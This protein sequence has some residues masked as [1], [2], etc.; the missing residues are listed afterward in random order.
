M[1]SRSSKA[2]HQ[3]QPLSR[4]RKANPKRSSSRAGARAGQERCER[5]R[6]S[7]HPRRHPRVPRP[8]P[9]RR[10]RRA[11][12][13][14]QASLSEA[15]R[16]T[17]RAERQ[18]GGTHQRSTAVFAFRFFYEVSRS[19]FQSPIWTIDQSSGKPHDT[20]TR[21]FE[22][23]I[24]LLRRSLDHSQNSIRNSYNRYCTLGAGTDQGHARGLRNRLGLTT[25]R[26]RA[27]EREP[28]LQAAVADL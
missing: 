19:P 21:A 14:A 22:L 15:P 8:R 23:S 11:R 4:I 12:D 13:A 16:E 3:S 2:R 28:R 10:R 6:E 25:T 26:E 7:R 24:D 5:T 17:R 27:R 9:R 1:N 20:R 18:T